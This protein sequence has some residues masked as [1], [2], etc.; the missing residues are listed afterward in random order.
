[1]KFS[2]VP[3]AAWK[4]GWTALRIS[5]ILETS[6]STTV[7]SWAEETM[8]ATARS[9]RTFLNLDIGS[10]VPRWALTGAGT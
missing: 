4:A 5:A 1:M 9:A 3:V 10:E 8:D 2:L 6:T 7:V